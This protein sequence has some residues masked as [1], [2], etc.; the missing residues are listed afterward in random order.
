MPHHPSQ[1]L[2]S[3]ASCRYEDV[4]FAVVI[5]ATQQSKSVFTQQA[6]LTASVLARSNANSSAPVDHRSRGM[7]C[8]GDLIKWIEY[9]PAALRPV[10][11][12]DVRAKTY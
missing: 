9:P 10:R 5:A 11:Q 3:V 1:G 8:W 4:W 6:F 12:D 7:I 2:V